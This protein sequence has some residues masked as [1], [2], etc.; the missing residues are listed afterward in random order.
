MVLHSKTSHS[1]IT[2]EEKR[3]LS[4]GKFAQYVEQQAEI[5]Q[6]LDEEVKSENIMLYM[7]QFQ[8]FSKRRMLWLKILKILRFWN[9]V[10]I[11][12]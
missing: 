7:K 12:L 5:F 8:K 3:L 2:D 4:K 1:A 9:G 6:K 10:L 11:L